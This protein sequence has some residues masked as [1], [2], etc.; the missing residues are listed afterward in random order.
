MEI[1]PNLVTRH[2]AT[3]M[4]CAG[5]YSCLVGWRG[6]EPAWI[7]CEVETHHNVWGCIHSQQPRPRFRFHLAKGRIV[8]W[9]SLTPWIEASLDRVASGFGDWNPFQV[10]GG[11]WNSKG[12]YILDVMGSRED[13]ELTV[14]IVTTVRASNGSW[15][16]RD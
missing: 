9:V 5:T 4:A 12:E 14:R 6:S 15:V 2:T 10:C 11:E 8:S 7:E 3:Q 13:E 16:T 1:L